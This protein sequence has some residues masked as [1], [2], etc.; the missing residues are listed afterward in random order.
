MEHT[1]A[2]GGRTRWQHKSVWG[3][4]DG[5]TNLCGENKMVAR[6]CVGRTKWRHESVWGEQD[7]G[8]N[9][10]EENKMAA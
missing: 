4:Q 8:M 2:A 3:E 10:C 6:I 7:G 5:G 9:Q 1:A